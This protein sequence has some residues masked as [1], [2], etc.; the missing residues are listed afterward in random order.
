MILFLIDS[1]VIIDIL[2]QDP[3]WWLWSVEALA[4]V[5]SIGRVAINPIIYAEVSAGFSDPSGL[6]R[7]L[8]A[9]DY[10]RLDLPWEAAP[11]AGRAYRA[12]RRAGGTRRSPLPD[13]YIGAHAEV[14]GL[15]LVTRDAARYRT[16]FPSV[17]L[18]AP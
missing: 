7:A 11:V 17:T 6:A 10:A 18:V 9:V 13:F 14:S 15:T 2:T 5:R 3:A 16:Y 12:Y 1:N 8:P 4:R